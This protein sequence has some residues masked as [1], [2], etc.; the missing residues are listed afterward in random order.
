MSFNSVIPLRYSTTADWK[1]ESAKLEVT[2]TPCGLVVGLCVSRCDMSAG[3]FVDSGREVSWNGSVC[4]VS[5]LDAGLAAALAWEA[6]PF[7][8]LKSLFSFKM[9]HNVVRQEVKIVSGPFLPLC[10]QWSP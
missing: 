8:A 5:L 10:Q 2:L 4:T 3:P 6:D 1:L 7:G 9:V